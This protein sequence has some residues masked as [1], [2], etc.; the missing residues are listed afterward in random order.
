MSSRNAI[1]NIRR[2]VSLSEL[3]PLTSEDIEKYKD[4][5][6]ESVNIND[7]YTVNEFFHKI[8]YV[9]KKNGNILPLYGLSMSKD[10]LDDRNKYFNEALKEKRYD[11]LIGLCDGQFAM[12]CYEI[13]EPLIPIEDRYN[14]FMNAYNRTDFNFEESSKNIDVDLILDSKRLDEDQVEELKEI[15]GE[16]LL[17]IYRAQGSKSTSLDKAISWTTSLAVAERFAKYHNLSGDGVIYAAEV[18]LED[19]TDYITNRNEEE[20]IVSNYYLN[21]VRLFDDLK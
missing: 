16:D 19:I 9:N 21:N 5:I 11:D 14:C 18:C 1:Y 8:L 2:S 6:T 17:T 20:I 7:L 3:K 4:I 13:I 15:C 10:L 12:M